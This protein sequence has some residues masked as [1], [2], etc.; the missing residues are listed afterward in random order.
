MEKKAFYIKES[1]KLFLKYGIKSVTVGQI[2]QQLNVSSKTL[3]QL[4]GDKTGLV[5]ECLELYQQNTERAYQ[6]LLENADNVADA[7][8]GF[9]EEL[10]ESMSR[11][12]PNFLL[13]IAR[14]FPEVWHRDQAFGIH[15]TLEL[16]QRGQAE[17]LFV[18]GLDTDICAR[19]I[20][21]LIRSMFQQDP[22][23]EHNPNIQTL[24]NNVLWPFL[25]GI[26]TPEGLEAFRKYRKRT[27][28]V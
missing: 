19:T 25:R 17:H 10:I 20:T 3:Y 23:A 8:M 16:L 26:S 6:A 7:L 18:K 28:Q 15:H 11:I 24:T 22:F 2:T 9:Y 1:L 5:R 21:L 13:D 4:F 27:V 12:N 14:F